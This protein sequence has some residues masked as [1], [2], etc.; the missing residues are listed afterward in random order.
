MSAARRTDETNK[1]PQYSCRHGHAG[2]TSCTGRAYL[3]SVAHEAL[4]AQVKRLRAERWDEDAATAT[5]GLDAPVDPR[6]DL[7]RALDGAHEEM[8]RHIR[9][10]NAL[11][12]DPTPAEVA[13][14]RAVGREISE[15]ITALEAQLAAVP[16]PAYSLPDL[17]ALHE[18]FVRTPL[19]A[20]I[21]DLQA[22]GNDGALR[23]LALALVASAKVVDRVP[24]V[25]TRWARAEVEWAADVRFLLERGALT[26]GPDV[27][28]PDHE[29]TQQ[30][31]ARERYLRYAA[32]KKAGL[33]GVTPPARSGLAAQ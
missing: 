22:Q 14:H 13:A 18:R 3:Q 19:A 7:Q 1:K 15:R 2:V 23:D 12:E 5:L 9:R 20:T 16:A 26:L 24:A 6:A 33:V 31:Q 32:R 28:R 8:K 30:Q 27:Q 25:K 21:E 17:R 29:A 11:I 4:L 10:F